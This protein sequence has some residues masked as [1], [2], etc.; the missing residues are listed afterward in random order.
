MRPADVALSLAVW[1]QAIVVEN[2]CYELDTERGNLSE[3]LCGQS[4]N[5]Q[6]RPGVDFDAGWPQVVVAALGDN[7][8]RQRRSSIRREGQTREMQLAGGDQRSHAAV[9]IVGD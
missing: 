3:I 5:Q 9:H 1:Q 8:H 7:S 2:K 4:R 6:K